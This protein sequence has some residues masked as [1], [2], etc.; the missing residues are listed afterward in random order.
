LIAILLD[1]VQNKV[2]TTV[3]EIIDNVMELPRTDRSYIA[4]KLIESLDREAS[5]SNEW[6]EEIEKRVAR[7]ESGESQSVSREVVHVDIEK[8]LAR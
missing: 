1:P 5:L 8:L 2:M 4:R 6:M 7:R 3:T